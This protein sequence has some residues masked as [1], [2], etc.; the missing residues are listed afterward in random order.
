MYCIL[1]YHVGSKS[2]LCKKHNNID[3]VY[4][5]TLCTRALGNGTFTFCFFFIYI[6]CL[7]RFGARWK[8]KAHGYTLR[9]HFVCILKKGKFVN[10]KVSRWIKFS[11]D[12]NLLENSEIYAKRSRAF[13]ESFAGMLEGN[14][15]RLFKFFY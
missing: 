4:I 5:Y 1:I 6:N 15:C 2:H 12:I 7:L 13:C 9:L 14:G 3:F 11:V 10:V 8:I